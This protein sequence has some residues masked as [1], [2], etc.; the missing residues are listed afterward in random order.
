[1]K[2]SFSM[3]YFRFVKSFCLS[4]WLATITSL[5]SLSPFNASVLPVLK[6]VFFLPDSLEGLLCS[7][8]IDSHSCYS[9]FMGDS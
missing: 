1:M 8:T 6:Y 9:S 5:A 3:L 2:L 4:Y 7:I